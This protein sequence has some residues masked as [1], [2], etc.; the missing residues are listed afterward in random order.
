MPSHRQSLRLWARAVILFLRPVAAACSV[1]TIMRTLLLLPFLLVA[2]PLA[3]QSPADETLD[4]YFIDTEGGQATLFVTPGG[5]SVL[6][7]TGNPGSRDTDRIL[8][9]LAEAG[10]EAID[11]LLITHYHRDHHGG[12]EELARRIAVRHFIDH[13]PSV[14]AGPPAEAFQQTYAALREGARHTQARPGDQLEIDGLEWEIVAAGGQVLREPRAAAGQPNPACPATRPDARAD[15][16]NGQ[17]TGSLIRF[18]EFSTIDLGDL[19]TAQE[20]DLMCPVNRVGSVDLYITSHH[21]VAT[22][23]SS[24]LVHALQ[25]RV[26]IMNNGTRKGGAPEVFEVLHR[27][28]ALRD[29]WQLHWS[30]NAGVELNAPGLFIA[31]VDEPQVMATVVTGGDARGAA[32]EGPAHAIHVSARRDGSFTVTNARNGFS[33]TYADD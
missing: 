20:Y 26:A 7:D 9:T 15:D 19:L 6:V 33:K 10:V 32:H 21:G 22:S 29:V 25:P 23:G 14:E 4:I 16:E 27:S 1:P 8:A 31:N 12:V 17:S 30:H 2:L 24:A 18:G 13:G 5:E 3:A 11:H 28:P